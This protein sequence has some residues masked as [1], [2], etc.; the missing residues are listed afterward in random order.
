MEPL[1]TDMEVLVSRLS[2]ALEPLTR[3]PYAV[4]GHSMGALLG[5]ALLQSLSESGSPPPLSFVA[6]GRHPPHR[7]APLPAAHH[8]DDSG[9]VGRLKELEATPPDILEHPDFI[10]TFLPIV[11]A[12]FTLNETYRWRETGKLAC[13][14][15]VFGGTK[16]REAPPEGLE[17]WGELT[18]GATEV[19][20]FDEGH[21]FVQNLE[22]AVVDLTAR[23]IRRSAASHDRPA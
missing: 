3:E 12:D 18:A 20:I 5:Y 13:P 15:Y 1:I 21:F 10:R 7:P 4:F 22:P 16:D 11:R 14:I 8:L 23:L 17:A 19:H 9:L 2:T 6:A